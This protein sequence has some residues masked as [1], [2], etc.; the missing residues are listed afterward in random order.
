MDKATLSEDYEEIKESLKQL[1]E[2]ANIDVADTTAFEA[3]SELVKN[4]VERG[5][6]IK[7]GEYDFS[8]DAG[9]GG[10][11]E[12]P[13]ELSETEQDRALDEKEAK[14][15]ELLDKISSWVCTGIILGLV[16]FL[17]IRFFF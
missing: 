5:E 13:E 14:E 9:T 7:T 8:L 11:D 10:F 2:R 16:I 1:G 12:I 4:A 6:K 3:F 15:K 17:V